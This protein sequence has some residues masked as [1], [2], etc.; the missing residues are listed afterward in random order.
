[1]LERRVLLL[2]RIK[3]VLESQLEFNRF[4]RLIPSIYEDQQYKRKYQ[5][6]EIKLIA[7]VNSIVLEIVYIYY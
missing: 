3:P 2:V 6:F 4:D 1:M 5:L 7:M